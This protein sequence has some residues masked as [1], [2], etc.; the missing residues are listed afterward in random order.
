MHLNVPPGP[1]AGGPCEC[2]SHCN[3]WLFTEFGTNRDPSFRSGW[4]VP[5]TWNLLEVKGE[6][7]CPYFTSP[8]HSWPRKNFSLRPLIPCE[9]LT[10]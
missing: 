9:T 10:V 5:V 7:K 8:A 6:E 2:V 4:L 3:N 1:S